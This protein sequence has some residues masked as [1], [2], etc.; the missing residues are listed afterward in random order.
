MPGVYI[1]YPFCRQKCT[2]CNFS[3]GVFPRALEEKYLV[4]LFDEIQNHQWRWQPETLYIGG[5]TPGNIEEDALRRLLSLVPGRPWTEATL[6]AAPGSVS[7]EKALLWRRLGINRIS[8]GV[9]SFV[10]RAYCGS[11]T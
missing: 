11:R 9:Q 6:E 2:Y 8:L 4:A 5:G 10:S 7:R 3:S 1:S